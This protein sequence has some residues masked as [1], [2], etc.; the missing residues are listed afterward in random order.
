MYYAVIGTQD[1][2]V[3]S[4]CVMEGYI[5]LFFK[6]VVQIYNEMGNEQDQQNHTD[7]WAGNDPEKNLPVNRRKLLS[8]QSE[9]SAHY[10]RNKTPNKK[11]LSELARSILTAN[12]TLEYEFFEF[13]K[14]RLQLQKGRLINLSF[15]LHWCKHE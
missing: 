15:P 2:I 12:M 11:E 1:D 14:Q 6:G 3:T 9:H 4:Q 13:V 8:S 7:I 10:V 5:P